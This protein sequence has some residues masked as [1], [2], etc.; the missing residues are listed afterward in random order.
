META[1]SVE[2]TSTKSGNIKPCRYYMRYANSRLALRKHTV[3]FTDI[4]KSLIA[5]VK[6]LASV[7]FWI[8]YGCRRVV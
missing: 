7:K 1:R 4:G 8:P 5:G 6:V 3:P 2:G